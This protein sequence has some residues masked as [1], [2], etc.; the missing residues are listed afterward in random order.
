MGQQQSSISKPNPLLG[1]QAASLA[2]NA[3]KYEEA[4][5]ILESILVT[6]SSVDLVKTAAAH[7]L[8]CLQNTNSIL[9]FNQTL[10]MYEY[11]AKT[12][13]DNEML[14]TLVSI[15]REDL[16]KAK[17][18]EKKREGELKYQLGG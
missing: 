3:G 12:R 11:L 18:V 16:S 17:E 7:R 13:P 6:V 10:A 1:I 2:L 14:K 8:L 9:H 15:C 5:K 4:T